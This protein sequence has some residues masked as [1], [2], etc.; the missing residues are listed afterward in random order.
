[1]NNV[2]ETIQDVFYNAQWHYHY[3]D[4]DQDN[5]VWMLGE[6]VERELT[7]YGARH[8]FPLTDDNFVG[9]GDI[10]EIYGIEVS[11]TRLTN[12]NGIALIF[13]DSYAEVGSDE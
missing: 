6:N 1:M 10:K 3:T 7:R 12:P 4:W 8:G 2:L 9:Y 5:F 11:K 13:R